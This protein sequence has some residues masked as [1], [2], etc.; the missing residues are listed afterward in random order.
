MFSKMGTIRLVIL[1][2]S[3]VLLPHGVKLP[4]Q[5]R[6][7]F[8]GEAAPSKSKPFIAVLERGLGFHCGVDIRLV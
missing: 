6:F 4:G 8:S 1:E 2:A 3:T 7:E 5:P